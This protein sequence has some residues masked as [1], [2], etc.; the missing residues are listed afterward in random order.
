MQT[1]VRIPRTGTGLS[2]RKSAK[3]THWIEQVTQSM[4]EEK[5]LPEVGAEWLIEAIFERYGPQFESF[6]VRKGYL[7]PTT[8]RMPKGK[9]A[10]MWT[11]GNVSYGVQRIIN[12]HCYEH[13]G[14]WIFAKEEDVRGFG[15]TAMAPT[16]GVSTNEKGRHIS[17]GETPHDMLLHEINNMLNENNVYKL[18]SVDFY[19]GGDHGKGRF[20]HMLTVALR[21]K[22]GEPDIIERH[23]IQ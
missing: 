13:F 7:L 11:E 6:C 23:S 3:Q 20:R 10:A 19:T 22:E 5:I 14:R 17:T 16:I 15:D 8:A 21:F 4:Y 1:A 2:F 9:S 18:A 12:Q